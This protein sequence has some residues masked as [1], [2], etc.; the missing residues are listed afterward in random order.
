[1]RHSCSVACAVRMVT[2]LGV[3]AAGL[4]TV[5]SM[6]RSGASLEMA[7]EVEA[8][9]RDATSPVVGTWRLVGVELLG[10]TG[11]TLPVPAAPAFGSANPVGLMVHGPGG[12]FGVSIMQSGRRPYA[13]PQPTPDEAKAAFD[14]F[15]AYFGT[16]RAHETTL[17]HIVEG[18]LSPNDAGTERASAFERRGER[19]TLTGSWGHAAERARLVWDRVPPVASPTSTHKQIAGF[20]RRAGRER[21]TLDGTLHDSDPVKQSGYLIFTASGY[22]A[23]HGMQPGRSRLAGPQATAAEAKRALDT[24]G[25]A[26]FG[27]YTVYES[28]RLEVTK[29]IGLIP[30]GQVGNDARRH[31][32]FRSADHLI[33]KPPVEKVDGRQLQS[34]V[35]WE[36]VE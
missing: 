27:P 26:Y 21:K 35:H 12:H 11:N 19:L 15:L 24:Y 32:E 36:R 9:Q 13:G 30:P 5:W 31:Y 29:Q 33:L 20:W 17:T 14:G 6:P 34:F 18:G 3:L 7:R 25:S 8:A 16:Y 10:P 1:M 22:M 4:T 2:M 23:V 28:E